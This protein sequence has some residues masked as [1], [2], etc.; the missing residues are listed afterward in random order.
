MT[1]RDFDNDEAGAYGAGP[2]R[3]AMRRMR[4]GLIVHDHARAFQGS[5]CGST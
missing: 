1:A 2:R 4:T 3:R 5:S